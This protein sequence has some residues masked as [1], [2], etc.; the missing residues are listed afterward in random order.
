MKTLKVYDSPDG[1]EVLCPFCNE[2]IFRMNMSENDVP[3]GVCE[4]LLFVFSPD[5]CEFLEST[6][7]IND[8]YDQVSQISEEDGFEFDVFMKV[9]VSYE[10]IEKLI[11]INLISTYDTVLFCFKPDGKVL[12]LTCPI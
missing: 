11:C 8:L 7:L 5:Q 10:D 2:V 4:H 3:N 12:D 9:L 1:C 6:N